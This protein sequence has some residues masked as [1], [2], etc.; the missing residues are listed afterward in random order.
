NEACTYAVQ[1]Q[2]EKALDAL[3]EA[4]D[5]GFAQ[6]ELLAQDEELAPLR[7]SP[8]FQELARKLEKNALQRAGENAKQLVAAT[9]PFPFR[10]E[11]ADPDGK[12]VTLDDVKGKVIIVDVWGTWCPPCQKELPHFKKLLETHREH[13]LAIVGI[14]YERVAAD[15]A[16]KTVKEFVK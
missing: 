8:R 12:S 2:P 11:L 6:L 1:N 5:A 10:F 16:R 14:N 13:G 9:R 4:I 7:S 3:G 15:D